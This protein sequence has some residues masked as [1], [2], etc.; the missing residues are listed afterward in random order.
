MGGKKCLRLAPKTLEWVQTNLM[1][2]WFQLLFQKNTPCQHW[3]K[4]ASDFRFFLSCQL[5]NERYEEEGGSWGGISEDDTFRQGDVWEGGGPNLSYAALGAAWAHTQLDSISIH[6]PPLTRLTAEHKR[7]IWLF[8]VARTH[9]EVTLMWINLI[10]PTFSNIV[11]LARQML[12]PQR[13]Q[14][15]L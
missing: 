10:W 2:I 11:L 12:M 1:V 3:G 15:P 9:S 5:Q 8:Y 13:A 7:P 6:L 14:L 4:A